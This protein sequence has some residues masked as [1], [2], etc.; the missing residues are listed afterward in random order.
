LHDAGGAGG[1]FD[2][3]QGRNSFLLKRPGAPASRNSELKNRDCMEEIPSPTI[4]T[5]I[6]RAMDQLEQG[7]VDSPRL[8]AEILMAH[9][10]VLNRAGLLSRLHSPISAE[11][12][13]RFEALVAKRAAGEPL[14]YLTGEKEFFGLVFRVSPAVLIPRPETEIL[15][16]KALQL[17]RARQDEVCLVDVGT[18]SGC[19]AI[20]LAH[21]FP[22]ALVFATDVSMAALS[23]ARVNADR[24]GV[25]IGWACGDLMDCF[26]LHPVFDLILSNPP[27]VALGEELPGM[28]RDYEPAAALFGGESGLEVFER[29]IPQAVIRLRPNGWLLLEAGVGQAS[30]VGD[31]LEAAGMEVDEVLEDW[32]KIPR[33]FVARKKTK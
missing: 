27:Y 17:T 26:P 13:R 5:A 4:W 31:L 28:V 20:C 30:A 15:V 33:C 29:L 32:Q 24:L 3:F 1:I 7:S 19:I 11:A 6:R 21:A 16:G 23:L 10:L 22:R 8:T 25:H 9:V 2:L 18:G 14:Q 12:Q